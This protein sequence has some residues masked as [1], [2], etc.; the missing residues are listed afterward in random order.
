QASFASTLEENAAGLG[1]SQG[2]G[3]VGD[4]RREFAA[5]IESRT[6]LAEL[7]AQNPQELGAFESRA[8]ELRGT[9]R[10]VA[11]GVARRAAAGLAGSGTTAQP[12]RN[13]GAGPGLEFARGKGN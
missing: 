9:A 2:V 1:R 13:A 10:K 4:L 12:A 7:N 8:Q 6:R 11:D 3:W 5:V